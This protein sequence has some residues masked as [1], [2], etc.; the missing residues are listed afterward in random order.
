MHGREGDE[1]P[2][3]TQARHPAHRLDARHARPPRTN[4][5]RVEEQIPKQRPPPGS[6]TK[7]LPAPVG[8]Q[9]DAH[10]RGHSHPLRSHRPLA[11]TRRNTPGGRSAGTVLPHSEHGLKPRLQL[12]RPRQPGPRDARH[13]T[14][15]AAV[16]TSR[17]RA[18]RQPTRGRH[19]PLGGQTRHSITIGPERHTVSASPIDGRIAGRAGRL[20]GATPV[21]AG[22]QHLPPVM[23]RRLS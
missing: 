22:I 9:H 1:L 6:P 3:G 20:L 17:T 13:Q 8:H 19:H 12:P 2:R 16:D 7:H 18:A 21:L 11:T 4:D 14:A 15:K 5:N 10:R 23:G